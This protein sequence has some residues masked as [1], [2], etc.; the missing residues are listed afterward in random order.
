MLNIQIMH[1][2]KT[3]VLVVLAATMVFAT[4]CSRKSHNGCPNNFGKLEKQDP[5]KD[6]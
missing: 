2:V 3:L 1:K 5:N 4:S 6:A